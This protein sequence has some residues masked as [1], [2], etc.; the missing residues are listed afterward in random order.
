MNATLEGW[1]FT[2]D[3]VAAH[4]KMATL[5]RTAA[6]FAASVLL[7]KRRFL[8]TDAS[9]MDAPNFSTSDICE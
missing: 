7:H 9:R 3:I 1:G 8:E 5:V 2:P 6:E 4:P